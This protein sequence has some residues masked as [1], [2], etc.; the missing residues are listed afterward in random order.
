V[1]LPFRDWFG[2]RAGG[3]AVAIILGLINGGIMAMIRK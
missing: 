1:D 2:H 3:V